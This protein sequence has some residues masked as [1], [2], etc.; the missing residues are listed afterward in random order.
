QR[1]QRIIH[2]DKGPASADLK[3][4]PLS[5]AYYHMGRWAWGS[6]GWSIPEMP[7]DTSKSA[8]KPDPKDPLKEERNTLRWIRQNRP[9]AVIQWTEITHPD[10]PGRKVEVGGFRPFV[11]MNPPDSL[12]DSVLIRQARFVEELAHML[13][14]VAIREV[15]VERVGAQ[16][17]RVTAQVANS[18]YLPTVSQLGVRVRWPQ[19]VR[20]ELKTSGQQIAGGRAIQLLDPIPG[21]GGSREFTWLVVGT[22]DSKL[23]LT[24]SS[25]VAGTAT[26]S[27]TL[28]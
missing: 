26:Q 19:R 21:N 12:L 28:R 17:F 4:D 3:G 24:A 6:P 23:T 1:F 7:A 9:D 5:F 25:P 10:F 27:I 8:P 14:S 2:Q 20:L 22:A 16:V 13:P 18:G 11:L 15:K